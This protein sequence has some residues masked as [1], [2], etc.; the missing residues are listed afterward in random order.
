[1]DARHHATDGC[2]SFDHH[3][4]DAKG[5]L[6]KE[7]RTPCEPVWLATIDVRSLGDGKRRTY[8]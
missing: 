7:G 8:I 2:S 1:V 4:V 3:S 6:S 5:I